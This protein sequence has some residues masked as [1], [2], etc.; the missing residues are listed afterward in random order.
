MIR[1]VEIVGA[2]H[3][4]EPIADDEIAAIKN[5]MTSVLPYDSHPY[6]HEGL[7]VE[8]VRGPLQGVQGIYCRKKNVID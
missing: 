1:V 6:L 2:D 7:Q 3:C 8:V 4:P 5:L